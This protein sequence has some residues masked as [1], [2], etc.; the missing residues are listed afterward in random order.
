MADIEKR[1]ITQEDIWMMR[2]VGAPVASPDGNWLATSV[3]APALTTSA[4]RMRSS[5]VPGPPGRCCAR[6]QRLRPATVHTSAGIRA[7]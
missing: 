4:S 7:S 5:G 1:A 6:S 2:R 3:L